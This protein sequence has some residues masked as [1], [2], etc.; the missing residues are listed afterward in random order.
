MKKIYIIL[1]LIFVLISCNNDNYKLYDLS[2]NDGVFLPFDTKT[3]STFYNFGFDDKTE[4]TYKIDVKLMGMPRDYDRKIKVIIE[5]EKYASEEF[6]ASKEEYYDI[7]NE[8]I[9][10][11]DSIHTYIPV[12]LIRNSELETSRAIITLRIEETEELVIRGHNEFTITFDDKMPNQPEWWL[13]YCMGEFSKI[14]AS[15][16]YKYFWEMEEKNPYFYNQIVEFG[17][18]NLDKPGLKGGN[19]PFFKFSYSMGIY[20]LTPCYEYS[21]AHPELNLGFTKPNIY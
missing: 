10:P 18:V 13:S 17:G 21:L 2:Q 19:N 20:V 1:S 8:V 3:D 16:V 11:K 15:L 6:I 5:N 9:L 14:S 7:P 4:F 12:K